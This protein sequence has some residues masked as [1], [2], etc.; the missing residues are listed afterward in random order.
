MVKFPGLWRRIGKRVGGDDISRA[1]LRCIGKLHVRNLSL[2]GGIDST[3]L[4]YFMTRKLGP[5]IHCYTIALDEDHPDYRHAKMAADY[6]GAEFHPYFLGE[7]TNGE[8]SVRTFYERLSTDGVTDII[9][10]DGIDEFSCGYYSHQKDQSEQNYISWIRRL[11]TEQL[12][13]LNKNSGGVHVYLPY[14]SPEVV[15]LLSL[16]PHFEKVDSSCRKKIIVE[17]ATG[18]IPEKI[19]NRWKFGFC[20]AGSRK[21][22]K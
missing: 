2:S 20:D 8:E 9:A 4:L 21:D 1:V 3:L 22:Q 7:T 16:I 19:I 5:P 18:N 14:L 15:M 11:N 17:M 10:G 12:V 6:F 13:P